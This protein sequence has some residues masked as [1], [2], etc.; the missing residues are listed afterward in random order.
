MSKLLHTIFSFLT[1]EKAK[2]IDTLIQRGKN[3]PQDY[4]NYHED[5]AAEIWTHIEEEENQLIHLL[6]T[7]QPQW[8]TTNSCLAHMSSHPRPIKDAFYIVR[9]CHDNLFEEFE[10][11]F[12]TVKDMDSEEYWTYRRRLRDQL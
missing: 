7:K 2:E 12:Q 4:I 1:I 8:R 10:T 3:H 11:F 9:Y 5:L 6:D